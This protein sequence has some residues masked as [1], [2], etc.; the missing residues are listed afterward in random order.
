MFLKEVSSARQAFVYLI[1]NTAKNCNIVVIIII[2]IIIIIYFI[3]L[4]FKTTV[5]YLN[6]F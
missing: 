4:Q 1:Q 5:F 6:I 2:I 3:F